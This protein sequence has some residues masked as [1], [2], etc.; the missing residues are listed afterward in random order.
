MEELARV[1]ARALFEA[2]REQGKLD[3]LREQLAQFAD[4]LT[5]KP[6]PAGLLL[7]ALLLDPGEAGR[8]RPSALGRRR[9][10]RELP[11][12]VDREPPDAGDLPHPARVRTAVGSGEPAAAR[13]DHERDRARRRDHRPGRRAYRPEHR[14]ARSSSPRAWTPRS[15]A[16]SWCGSATRSSTPRSATDWSSCAGTLPGGSRKAMQITGRVELRHH[17]YGVTTAG[18]ACRPRPPRHHASQKQ[19]GGVA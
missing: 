14:D 4:A 17:A 12:A 10:S 2:A 6:R 13:G 18:E 7:L 5:G 3:E 8:A 9:A 1:Y 19:L 15:S 16:A 11:Q